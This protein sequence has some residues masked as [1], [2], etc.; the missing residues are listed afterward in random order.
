MM[1]VVH[2]HR[3]L[4]VRKRPDFEDRPEACLYN[5]N[6]RSLV[7]VKR[8]TA[9]FKRGHKRLKEAST[10]PGRPSAKPDQRVTTMKNDEAA[11]VGGL[12]DE[13]QIS[14]FDCDRRKAL[15]PSALTQL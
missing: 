1:M 7:P 14:F 3:N 6:R 11:S 5:Q 15:P 9:K 4:H 13:A 8:A 2:R 12:N 10:M